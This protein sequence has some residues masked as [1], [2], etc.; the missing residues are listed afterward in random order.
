MGAG[1]GGLDLDDA[2]GRRLRCEE[3]IREWL[4]GVPVEVLDNLVRRLLEDVEVQIQMQFSVDSACK[5]IRSF[6]FCL[7]KPL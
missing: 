6:I 3:E 2:T 5:N 7:W 1:G 4:R